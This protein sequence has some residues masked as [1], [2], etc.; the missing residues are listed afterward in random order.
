MNYW[1]R[2]WVFWIYVPLFI[3]I[4]LFFRF[5]F[6]THRNELLL[7]SE[8]KEGGG[9]LP[10][11][12]PYISTGLR[13]L[14]PILIIPALAGPGMRTEFLPDEKNGIDLMIAL[15]VSGSMTRSTDF[16]P[17]N[18]LE[19]SKEMISDFIKRRKN[20]RLG[21][22]I[23]GGAAYLQSPL[24]GD[25]ESLAEVLLD[26]HE[27]S[28]QEQGTA[29]GDA[30]ALSTLRLKKSKAKSRVILL[31]TDGV[32]NTGKIDIDTAA[33]AAEKFNI[34][35]YSIGIGKEFGD[36]GISDVDFEGLEKIS[37]QTGAKFYRATDPGQLEK[38]LEDIDGLEK[39]YVLSKPKIFLESKFEIFL[40]PALLVF[41][42]DLLL[43]T[44]GW[45]YYI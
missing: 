5:R 3:S 24:T 34:K 6:H 2:A 27:G 40:I 18:R 33:E 20:D 4:F 37:I 26:V 31:L 42:L 25:M 10:L 45:K 12:A 41:A 19:V 21:L 17:K 43:R 8:K 36:M 14:V 9:V 35:I 29:I 39:T 13:F 23:F 11:F 32:S 38:V 16:L 30:L 44:F 22:V 1:E 28:V 7:S 15:D